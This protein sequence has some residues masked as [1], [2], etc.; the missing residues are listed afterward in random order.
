M[1]LY[2][3][4]SMD[5]IAWITGAST[6]IGRRL[7]LDLVHKGYNVAVTARDVDDLATLEQETA[8]LPGKVK[9]FPC[10]VTDC[11]EM[12][13]TVASIERDFGEITLAIFNAGSYFPTR[14]ERLN[15]LNIVRSYEV[16]IFGVIHGLVPVVDYMHN[17]GRGHIVIIGSVSAYF[18]WPSAA[19]YASTKSALNNL[20]ETLKHDFD[21]MNIRI[22]IVNP[23]FVDTPLTKRIDAWLPAMM[24]VEQASERILAHIHSGWFEASFP[25][26]LTWFL[27]IL[28]LLPTSLRYRLV[29]RLTGWE[30]QPMA[31]KRIIKTAR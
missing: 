10:D 21:R 5:G 26:R 9:S 17:R 28:K 29:H 24:S 2:R 4:N 25:R 13:K 20:A 15:T 27:K 22:Q 3:T 1:E 18:G 6:G 16:N 31:R 11:A 12:A 14:G 7:A 8:G 30:K 19:A 23:G